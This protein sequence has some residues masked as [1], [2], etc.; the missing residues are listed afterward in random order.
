MPLKHVLQGFTIF[1]DGVTYLGRVKG[2]TPPTVEA[3]V[4]ESDMP[5]HGGALDIPTGR[6]AKLEATVV[7]ADQMPELESLAAS[8]A[9]IETPVTLVRATTDGATPRRVEYELRGLWTKQEPGETGG[10]GGDEGETE[11]TYTIG[12]R[13]LTHLIDGTEVRYIHLER[14]IHRI[15]GTDVN[16]ALR[17]SL[18]RSA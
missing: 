7:M 1:V 17:Q 11:C 4:V 10:S 8:A 2:F 9:S 5:G 12:V 3:R 14:N 18:E 16:E 13:E 6:L 15:N